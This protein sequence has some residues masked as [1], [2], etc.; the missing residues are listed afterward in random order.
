MG[1]NEPKTQA[2]RFA[3]IRETYPTREEFRASI[4]AENVKTLRASAEEFEI[5]LEGRDKKA[6]ILDTIVRTIYAEHDNANAPAGGAEG[7]GEG[8]GGDNGDNTNTEIGDTPTPAHD[9]D[10]QGADEGEDPAPADGANKAAMY[11][12]TESAAEVPGAKEGDVIAT[13]SPANPNEK[14][15][16]PNEVKKTQLSAR[17]L[18]GKSE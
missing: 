13:Q 11:S 17:A 12:T 14:W 16:E 1:K 7:S 15:T 10:T 3:E 9:D 18:A 5:N 8:E 2:E 6:D 4:E